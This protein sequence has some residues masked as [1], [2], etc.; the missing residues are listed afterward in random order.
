[1]LAAVVRQERA[2][3]LRGKLLLVALAVLLSH[4]LTW[5]PCVRRLVGLE[6]RR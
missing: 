2:R 6:M 3:G 1:M 5:V 4:G